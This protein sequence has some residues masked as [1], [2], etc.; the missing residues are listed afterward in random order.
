MTSSVKDNVTDCIVKY[1]KIPKKFYRHIIS[2]C[3]FNKRLECLKAF[4]KNLNDPPIFGKFH[5]YSDYLNTL[6]L[7]LKSTLETEHRCEFFKRKVYPIDCQGDKALEIGP[8]TG[9]L[10]KYL[11]VKFHHLTVIDKNKE[12][13]D[14]IV[15]LKEAE[16][17][18]VNTIHSSILEV[19]LKSLAYSMA[20]ISHVLYYIDCKKWLTVIK[21][22]FQALDHGG[23]L[24]IVMNEGL[25]KSKLIRHFGGQDL[26]VDRL[27]IECMKQINASFELFVSKES[28]YALGI[29][30]MLHIAG[31]HLFDA[32]TV[33]TKGKLIQFIHEQCRIKDDLF[34]L[35]IKQKFILLYKK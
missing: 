3:Q 31:L 25:D 30:A 32:S 5:T 20:V 11:L 34:R 8:G 29:T 17:K 19:K 13:L 24:L 4:A 26:D 23:V 12:S 33:A 16:S 18:V 14:L 35:D 21:N 9:V 22:M 6:Q 15:Q 7:L 1:A 2:P 27:V 28:Y 10:T